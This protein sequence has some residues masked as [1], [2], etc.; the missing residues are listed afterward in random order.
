MSK[1]DLLVPILR[2]H[3]T[4]A[5]RHQLP[6]FKSSSAP[7]GSVHSVWAVYYLGAKCTKLYVALLALTVLSWIAAVIIITVIM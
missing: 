5:V 3:N 6:S 7:A 4:D 1:L 2:L